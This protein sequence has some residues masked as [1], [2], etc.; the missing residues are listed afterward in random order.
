MK[1]ISS[2]FSIAVHILSL[3]TLS[4]SPCTSDYIAASVNT[5]PVVIRRI[6]GLLKKAGLV[7]V[8]AG[9]GGTYLRRPPEDIT[10]LDVYR[11][12]EVVEEDDLFHFHEHPNPDCPVGRNIES[13]L[14]A[15]M[16]RAQSAMER[17]L[18]QVTLRQVVSRIGETSKN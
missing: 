15:D 9:T 8:K 7:T 13:T 4:T 3:V 14:R 18:A 5:N 1:K 11:A 17:E 6:T 2:R 16:H 12:V 10:L